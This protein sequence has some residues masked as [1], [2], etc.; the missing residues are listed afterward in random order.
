MV[1]QL[2]KTAFDVGRHIENY[3]LHMDNAVIIVRV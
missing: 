2:R 3:V 1:T